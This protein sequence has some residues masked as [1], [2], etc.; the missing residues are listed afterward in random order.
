MILIFLYLGCLGEKESSS[1]PSKKLTGNFAQCNKY[2]GE[3]FNYCIYHKSDYI[4]SLK[5]VEKYCSLTGAWEEACRYNWGAEVVRRSK[6]P[7]EELLVGCAGFSDCSFELLDERPSKE[8]GVQLER[9]K[10]Y[11][12]ADYLDCVGHALQ[13]WSNGAPTAKE[14]E[15]VFEV[16][17]ELSD[18]SFR[19][20]IKVVYC[21]K[22]TTC[23]EEG[24]KYQR[25][26]RELE[27]M[28]LVPSACAPEGTM[29]RKTPHN[30]YHRR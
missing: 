5:D 17:S 14:A 18:F 29:Q 23:N 6:L 19:Y 15:L 21:N 27:N 12:V 4:H 9:C 28:S 24:E 11:V 10:T 8:I 26:Q 22:F 20:L 16:T 3:A 30:F 2:E 25:C 13:R 1:A 7:V